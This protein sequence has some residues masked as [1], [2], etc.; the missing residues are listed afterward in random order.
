M[1]DVEDSDSEADCRWT[2]PSRPPRAFPV[3][4]DRPIG[5]PRLVLK[6]GALAFGRGWISSELLDDGEERRGQIELALD[7]ANCVPAAETF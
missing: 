1:E 3:A 2:A 6:L 7:G 5:S 4:L